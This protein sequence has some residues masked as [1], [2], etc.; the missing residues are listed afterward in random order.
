M[1][2]TIK[3]AVREGQMAPPFP[4]AFSY[5]NYFTG[6][7]FWHP[8]PLNYCVRGWRFVVASW[9]GWQGRAFTHAR[10]DCKRDIEAA[11][12][13]GLNMGRVIERHERANP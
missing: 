3:Q 11:Y 8:L 9:Y 2:L 10:V 1:R 7:T 4:W 6:V 12:Q 13:D 5:L